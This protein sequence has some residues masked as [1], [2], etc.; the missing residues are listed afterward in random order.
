MTLARDVRQALAAHEGDIGKLLEL[1]ESY[2]GNDVESTLELLR[3]F[4]GRI[5]FRVLAACLTE[6]LTWVGQLC[7]DPD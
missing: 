7:T 1:A 6:A 2:D 5:N 3:H 4:G